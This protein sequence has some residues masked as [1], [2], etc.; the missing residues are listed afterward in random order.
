M[1]E[2][3]LN[4]KNIGQI[5]VV[6]FCPDMLVIVRVDQLHAD[7]DAIAN[8][9]DAAFQKRGYAEGFSDFTGIAHAVAAIRH[10]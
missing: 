9:A 2:V 5:A 6:I 8:P 7:P 1:C 3:G 4:R 10:D